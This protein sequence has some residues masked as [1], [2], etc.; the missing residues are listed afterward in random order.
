[1]PPLVGAPATPSAAAEQQRGHPG[2]GKTLCGRTHAS[3]RGCTSS[4]CGAVPWSARRRGSSPA[5]TR[6]SHTATPTVIGRA[7]PARRGLLGWTAVALESGGAASVHPPSHGALAVRRGHAVPRR[8]G[9][10]AFHP[11]P[12]QADRVRTGPRAR[13]GS[14]QSS[15]QPA[16]HRSTVRGRGASQSP[17]IA[18]DSEPAACGGRAGPREALTG[19]LAPARIT[20]SMSRDSAPAR[21]QYAAHV[22]AGTGRRLETPPSRKIWLAR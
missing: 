18:H 20:T 17:R 2:A 3:S 4:G 22:G 10:S 6:A 16:Q 15:A 7:G 19:A 8:G 1:M 14:L 11:K 9:T 21:R 5:S 12:I 13:G